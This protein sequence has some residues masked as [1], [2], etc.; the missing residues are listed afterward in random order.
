FP[1]VISIVDTVSSFSAIPI[2]KDELGID[3][4]LTGTQKALAMPPGMALFSPSERA[5]KRA[6]TL[7]DRG[8]YFDFIEFQKN[9]EKGMTPSTPTIPHIYALQS[10]LEDIMA[11]GVEARY[12]RHE[13]LNG[14]VHQWIERNGFELFPELKHA[15]KTLSCISNTRKI[16]IPSLNKILKE[17]YH[18]VIDGGYGKIKG[19]TFR[20]SNMGDETEITIQKLLD[21]LDAALAELNTAKA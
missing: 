14:M 5:L 7:P 18:C 9:H 15:S 8:Y 19:K 17:T 20:I 13:K 6:E 3:I 12:A 1:E 2:K 11:E 21:D 10:K 16:D 4:F